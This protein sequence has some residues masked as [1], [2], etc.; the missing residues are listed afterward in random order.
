VTPA[1]AA[2]CVAGAVYVAAIAG[3][4]WSIAEL[5]FWGAPVV[6]W[7]TV[8]AGAVVAYIAIPELAEHLDDEPPAPSSIKTAA[9][10]VPVK[11]PPPHGQ[12]NP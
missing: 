10:P 4:A 1:V 2:R 6:A 8:L 3:V 5:G 9:A 7:L 11:G 12:Y